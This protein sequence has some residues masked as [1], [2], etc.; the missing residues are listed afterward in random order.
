MKKKN[1]FI[2][3]LLLMVFLNFNC[4]ASTTGIHPHGYWLDVDAKNHYVDLNLAEALALFFEQNQARSVVDFGC[5][6][7]GYTE[8]LRNHLIYCEAY[9]GNPN[10]SIISNGVGQVLD[11]SQPINLQH[12]FDW[13]L[14][15]EVG[16]HIPKTFERNFIKN[17]IVHAKKGV[18]LSWAQKGQGGHG[19]VNEQSNKYIKKKLRH[20]GFYNDLK[21]E[22]FLRKQAS[23][24]F[25]FKNTIMVFRKK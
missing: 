22:R 13:V 20:Y 25:A 2:L 12:K 23:S 5:G 9:D 18:I 8:V 21:T 15:L 19:H 1:K 10:T 11:L 16:E 6:T 3:F 17:L 7:G 24:N 14:S 4:Y